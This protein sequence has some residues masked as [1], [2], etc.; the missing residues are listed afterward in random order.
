VTVPCSLLCRATHRWFTLLDLLARQAHT[1]WPS[2]SPW[3]C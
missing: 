1:S 3:R 2:Y